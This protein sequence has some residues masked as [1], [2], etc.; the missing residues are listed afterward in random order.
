MPCVARDGGIP[1]NALTACQFDNVQKSSFIGD[2]SNV[3]GQLGLGP[4]N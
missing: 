3:T 4:R 1:L 2:Y